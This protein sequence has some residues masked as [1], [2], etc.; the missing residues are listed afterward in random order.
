MN[1]NAVAWGQNNRCPLGDHGWQLGEHDLWGKAANFEPARAPP[2]HRCTRHKGNGRQATGLVEFVDIYPSLCDLA[3][4]PL[5]THL[6]G[7]SAAPLLDA[8]TVLETGD[9]Y[10][11]ALPAFREWAACRSIN[12]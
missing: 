12:T 1:S 2:D 10:T 5:P 9:L 4:L 11:V 6:Q 8:P 3:R 7:T